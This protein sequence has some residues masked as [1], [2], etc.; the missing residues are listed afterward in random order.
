MSPVYSLDDPQIVELL[1][2]GAVGVIPTDTIYGIVAS[3]S[4]ENA[5]G[6]L[7]A[8]KSREQKPGT[9]IAANI[10]QLVD[11]GV[12]ADILRSI[13]YLWPNPLSIELQIGDVLAHVHQ[14]TGHGAFR[15]VADPV[16]SAL[17]EATG[18]LLTTSANLPGETPATTPNEAQAYFGDKVNFYVDGGPRLGKAPS[19]VARLEADGSFTILRSGAVAL[20]E[21]G[22][23]TQ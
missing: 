23:I 7:Y 5:V 11:I 2:H 21:K 18:P 3:V 6:R 12:D 15:V 14:G 1:L 9:V 10:Q 16:I 20:N 13:A 19:T 17:L 4:D 8:L 22:E